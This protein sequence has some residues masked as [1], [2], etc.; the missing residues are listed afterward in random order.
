MIDFVL[1]MLQQFLFMYK[2]KNFVKK[3]ISNYVANLSFDEIH[4]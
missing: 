1:E 2:I 4:N 3:I